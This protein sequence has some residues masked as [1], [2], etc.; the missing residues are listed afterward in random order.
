ML[1]EHQITDMRISLIGMAGVGKSTIG[2]ALARKIGCQFIDV[3]SLIIADKG[4]KLQELIDR[5]GD[6]A[7]IEIEEKAVISLN[8]DKDCVI[9]PGGSVVYSEKAMEYLKEKTTIVFLDSPFKIIEERMRNP[10]GRGVIGLKNNTINEI[11]KQRYELYQKYADI[12]VKMGKTSRINE[13]VGKILSERN[14]EDKT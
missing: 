3:D 1:F 4:M 13:I 14:I 7:L 9:S 5:Y 6:D 12:T 10:S 2:K 8:I 11:F